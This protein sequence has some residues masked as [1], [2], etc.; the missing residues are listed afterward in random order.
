[1]SLH[2]IDLIQCLLIIHW[3]FGTPIL[4]SSDMQLPDEAVMLYEIHERGTVNASARKGNNGGGGKSHCRPLPVPIEAD[5]GYLKVYI[6]LV[7]SF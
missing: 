2:G 3:G 1:M 6:D 5:S 7:S 4:L